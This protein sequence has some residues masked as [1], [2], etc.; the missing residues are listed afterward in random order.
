MKNLK[1]TKTLENLMKTFAGESQARNRYSMFASAARN[2]GYK[3]IEGIF[4]E[5]AENEREHAKRFYKVITDNINEPINIDINATFPAFLGKTADN[6]VSA[7]AGENE[8]HTKLYP[9]FADVADK[10]GFPEAAEVWRNISKVEV[11]H[12]KRY[13]KLAE[14]IRNS[15][16]FKKEKPVFW[17]C[18]NCGLIIE[19]K[20][21][22]EKCPACLHP[23]AWFEL[24]CENY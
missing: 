18:R 5:T 10:E 12:E 22:P 1:G 6:L 24:Q 3:Q 4:L 19:S 15:S 17:K 7:A 8:E 23:A 20:A 16:V 21:A 14:N 9:S 2:E 11:E 13:L